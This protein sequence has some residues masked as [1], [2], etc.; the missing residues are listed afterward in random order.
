MGLDIAQRLGQDVR[1][2]WRTLR[3]N[4][5]FTTMAVLSLALGSARIPRFT[6]SWTRS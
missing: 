1:Y 4:P 3:K 6:A 5:L 2:G